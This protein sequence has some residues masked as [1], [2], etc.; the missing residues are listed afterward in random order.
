MKWGRRRYQ[1]PDGTLTAEGKKRYGD[2]SE[3]NQNGRNSG[4]GKSTAKKVAI[5]V[6]VGLGVAAVGLM[7]YSAAKSRS[8]SKQGERARA[9]INELNKVL[10]SEMKDQDK[11]RRGLEEL[12]NLIRNSKPGD[13]SFK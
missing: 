4:K 5:G 10:I 13:T 6:G 11:V 9:K 8:G 12:D 7:A 2:S 3:K 1:N